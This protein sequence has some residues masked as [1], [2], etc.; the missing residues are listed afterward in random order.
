MEITTHSAQIKINDSEGSCGANINRR[1]GGY[2][3]ELQFWGDQ[4]YLARHAGD[5]V[6]RIFIMP[7]EEWKHDLE[8]EGFEFIGKL[9]DLAN[10]NE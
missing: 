5:S 1:S 10:A 7:R 4:V 6:L 9:S 8:S 3:A 2:V